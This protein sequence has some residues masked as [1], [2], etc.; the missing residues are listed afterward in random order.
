ML[1]HLP[2]APPVDERKSILAVL[3]QYKRAYE[4]QNLGELK[5]IWPSISERAERVIQTLFKTASSLQ[6][7]YAAPQPQ[8]A[9]D[10]ATI[11][12]VQTMSYVQDRKAIKSPPAKVVMQLRKQ[13]SGVW[14]I[15]SIR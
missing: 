8:I 7:D 9:G 1:E 5:S 10:V 15:E 12:F 11:S 6:L 2:Q 4:S 14:V 3:D 13:S